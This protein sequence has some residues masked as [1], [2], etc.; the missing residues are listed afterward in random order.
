MRFSKARVVLLVSVLAIF[1]ATYVFQPWQASKLTISG[2]VF[3]DLDSNGERG[4]REP[5]EPNV[6]VSVYDIEDNII[7]SAITDINGAYT[8]KLE[9]DQTAEFSDPHYVVV[10]SDW[11]DNLQPGPHGL[12]SG[13]ELQFASP[14]QKNVS[15]GLIDPD[16]YVPEDQPTVSLAEQENQPSTQPDRQWYFEGLIEA[17]EFPN[18]LEWLN[19]ERPLTMKDL[20]GK[21]VILEYWTY[22]CIACIE[23]IPKLQL[24][25]EAYPDELV[26]IGVHS[27]KYPHE[28]I[29][30]NILEFVTRYGIEYPL[31]NDVDYSLASAYSANV[32]PT[33]VIITP[34]GKFLHK[35]PG[36]IHYSDWYQLVGDM[37][38]EF[39]GRELVNRQPLNFPSN[40]LTST[41]SG[42]S[43]PSGI[44]ADET[45]QRLFIADSANNRIVV[46]DFLG[47]V[48]TVIGNGEPA[49]QD[50]SYGEASFFNP[51]GMALDG[52]NHLYVA[53]T[54]NHLIRRIDLQSQM[55]ETVAG[56]GERIYVGVDEGLALQSRLRFPWDL[57]FINNLLY[58]SM[59]GQHQLWRYDPETGLLNRFAGT[60]IESLV[61]G[62]LLE[63][64]IG[65]P[66]AL[67]TDGEVLFFAGSENNSIRQA[68]L[69]P[70]GL[71]Q[72]IIGSGYWGFG[73]RDGPAEQALLQFP[74]GLAHLDG[75]LYIA[76][77][78]N[79]KIK[80]LDLTTAYTETILGTGASGAGD[81]FTPMFNEPSGLSVIPDRLFV[82]DTNNHVI[83]VVDLLTGY[84]ST[85]ALRDPNNLLASNL[86]GNQVF[87]GTTIQLPTQRVA[88]GDGILSVSVA[89]L[90]GY[91]FNNQA[92]AFFQWSSTNE[93]QLIISPEQ[94]SLEAPEFPLTFYASF[95]EGT[96]ELTGTFALYYCEAQEESLC[97][98]DEVR[99]IVPVEIVS[100]SNQNAIEI[101]HTIDPTISN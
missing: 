62:P 92:P 95:S 10:F 47:E 80:K 64:G 71:V 53:D 51:Q 1:A 42:L 59:A 11:A 83:R 9:S 35:T 81:G 39:D 57:A 69:D 74:A 18:N 30:E 23:E 41:E 38:A 76:D 8:L 16:Q 94:L 7:A 33:Y 90:E 88:P 70:D 43:F 98:L 101:V 89:L 36:S 44:L 32:W 3:R 26:I 87:S 58:F 6:S 4:N 24:L 72:T 13:T 99:F 65:Q 37:I 27:A 31:I 60:G 86:E 46:T 21:V 82:A 40:A 67:A 25:A 12:D 56:I 85:L 2:T 54:N 45:S 97:F 75:V 20:R 29:T 68:H 63:A 93:T 50:G 79:N 96:T 100:S 48:L 78:F 77:T 5:G 17:P 52:E 91:K 49:W 14:G 19:V 84:T 22:G 61:D 15:F 34:T 73:D 28:S 55:V 66:S